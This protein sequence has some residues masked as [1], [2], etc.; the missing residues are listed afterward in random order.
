MRRVVV[1]GMGII[2]C[3]GNDLNTVTESLMKAKPGI[4]FSD[5]YAE[6]AN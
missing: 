3:I 2:S 5:E 1:T 4:R 6:L